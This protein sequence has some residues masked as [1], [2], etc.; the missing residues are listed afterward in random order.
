MFAMFNA[1]EDMGIIWL[2]LPIVRISWLLF[3]LWIMFPAQI[4]RSA[5][6]KA[7]T[8]RWK[9]AIAGWFSPKVIIIIPSWLRVERAIIFFRSVSVQAE[10]LAI[11]Q[12]SIPI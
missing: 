3:I 10:R 6:N 2:I 7:W 5:L 9:K 1:V 12:V 4:K 8:I 11:K